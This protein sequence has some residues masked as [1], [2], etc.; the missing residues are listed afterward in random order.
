MLQWWLYQPRQQIRRRRCPWPWQVQ[1][2]GR[3]HSPSSMRV[4]ARGSDFLCVSLYDCARL[5]LSSALQRSL[6]ADLFSGCAGAGVIGCV[7]PRSIAITHSHHITPPRQCDFSSHCCRCCQHLL[8]S[9]LPS[10]LSLPQHCGH[11]HQKRRAATA[12]A[13]STL[14]DDLPAQIPA[15]LLKQHSLVIVTCKGTPHVHAASTPS[16]K[17]LGKSRNSPTLP[18]SPAGSKLWCIATG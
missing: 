10:P 3:K 1:H 5:V 14:H 6:H 16:S 11:Q 7:H 2:P 8:L 4:K 13:H 9:P 17:T 12:T 15:L 18:S